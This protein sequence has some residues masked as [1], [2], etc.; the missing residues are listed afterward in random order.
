MWGLGMTPRGQ[1]Q[2]QFKDAAAEPSRDGGQALRDVDDAL[3]GG[4]EADDSLLS[5]GATSGGFGRGRG[6]DRSATRG[7]GGGAV[8]P[9]SACRAGAGDRA[10]ESVHGRLGQRDE[11]AF[12][13]DSS[14]SMIN[15]FDVLRQNCARR[16]TGSSPI[17]AFDIIF[18]SEDKSRPWTSSCS[19]RR[20]RSSGRPTTSSRRRR[21]TAHG[22][23]PGIELAF[24]A[25]PQLIYMLT[26]GDFNNNA[27][28]LEEIR[29]LNKD[30]R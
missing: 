9:R 26:D 25:E 12:V 17:Q 16:S 29:K 27:Q 6:A 20:R 7:A 14:G 15:K 30:S 10:Q 24:K 3:Q 2:D 23:D 21:R 28:M 19:W 18:F 13:C 4:G 5:V 22:P 1:F 8:G 11:V